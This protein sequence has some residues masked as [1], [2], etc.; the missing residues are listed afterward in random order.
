MVDI[1]Q[2]SSDVKVNV[3]KRPNLEV[4]AHDAGHGRAI[5]SELYDMFYLH[6]PGNGTMLSLP[7]D[8]LVEHGVGH[9]VY[10][11]TSADP[12]AVINLANRGVFS[13]LALSI[14]QAQR[15]QNLI[16]PDLPLI[17]KVDGHLL[18]GKEVDHP[19]MA[20]MASVEKALEVGA[21]AI[22]Y[23]FYIGGEATQEDFERVCAITE[24]AHR[25]GK[26]VFMWAYSRGP[27]VDQMGAA[28]LYWSAQGVSVAGSIGADVVKFKYPERPKDLAFYKGAMDKKGY[29]G[30]K[31]PEVVRF[32]DPAVEI[33]DDKAEYDDEMQVR[34]AALC[35]A[36]EP[37]LLKINS[38]G[39]RTPN[40]D[41]L[42]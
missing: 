17:V 16:R 5:M 13:A 32:F 34:R 9:A 33:Q 6:G 4:I 15:Y 28:S 10:N 37:N 24:E 21:N 18:V 36:I 14:G 41:G 7:F 31:M 38:G 12:R 2:L 22:G 40:I 42:L 26:P 11:E 23:T 8:Q 27:F 19:R 1:K 30:S 29:L 20:T 25:H 35:A 39:P 3:A